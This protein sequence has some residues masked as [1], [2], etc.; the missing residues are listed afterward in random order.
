MNSTTA[1]SRRNREQGQAE[2]DKKQRVIPGF[3]R[4]RKLEGND[5]LVDVVGKIF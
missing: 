4:V 3:F 1:T 5:S 2:E